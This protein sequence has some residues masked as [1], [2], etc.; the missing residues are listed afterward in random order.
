M[1][2]NQLVQMAVEEVVKF[3]TDYNAWRR[4][5]SDEMPQPKQTGIVL[6]SAISILSAQSEAQ[7]AEGSQTAEEYLRGKYGAYRGHHA[8]RELEEAFNAGRSQTT[9]TNSVHCEKCGKSSIQ[10]CCGKPM[11]STAPVSNPQEQRR[12]DV[13]EECAKMSACACMGVRPGDQ[14]CYCGL[15]SRGLCT[16]H[17]EWTPEEKDR[18]NEALQG[19][20][21]SNALRT[22]DNKE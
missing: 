14:H 10:F 20:F 19:F 1:T 5:G 18:L 15:K 13:I 22:L 7:Q 12:D 16:K 3:L 4:G 8:W 11:Q 9:K 17:Y 2:P 21:G 6:D